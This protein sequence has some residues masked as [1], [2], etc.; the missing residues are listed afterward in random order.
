MTPHQLNDGESWEE[1]LLDLIELTNERRHVML[2]LV[3]LAEFVRKLSLDFYQFMGRYSI[4]NFVSSDK[5]ARKGQVRLVH[6]SRI[7]TCDVLTVPDKGFIG[8]FRRVLGSF[9]HFPREC[10]KQDGVLR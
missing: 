1:T 9:N 5:G 4:T 7:F 2:S 6:P 8:S 10:P 3:D